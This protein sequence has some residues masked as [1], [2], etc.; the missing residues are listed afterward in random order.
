MTKS[1]YAFTSKTK[2]ILEVWCKFC[3]FL[4]N[5]IAKI[6]KTVGQVDHRRFLSVR[7]FRAGI[8][9][10]TTVSKGAVT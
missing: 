8:S 3:F 9:D 10:I 4:T 2:I 1:V 5:N 6:V 7:I